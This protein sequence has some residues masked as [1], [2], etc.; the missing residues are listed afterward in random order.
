MDKEFEAYDC[1]EPLNLTTVIT[2]PRLKCDPPDP[3]VPSKA[4]TYRILQRA[5]SI[6]VKL[7]RCAATRSRT[8]FQCSAA[9]KPP[10]SWLHVAMPMGAEWKFE[11]QLLL[12]QSE[13]WT[14]WNEQ[15]YHDTYDS[16]RSYHLAVP[17][18]QTVIT[19]PSGRWTFNDSWAGC[20]SSPSPFRAEGP[21]RWG[22][23]YWADPEPRHF[24]PR[25]VITDYITIKTEKVDA[26]RDNNGRLTTVTGLHLPCLESDE[27]CVVE[28]HGTYVWKAT[29]AE[30]RCHYYSALPRPVTGLDIVDAQGRTTF[31][32][33][34]TMLRL[35][36]RGSISRCGSVMYRTDFDNLFLTED[37]W[38]TKVSR[39][40]A[41]SEVSVV[42][43]ANQQDKFLY[44]EVIDTIKEELQEMNVNQCNLGRHVK[45]GEYARQAAEQQARLDG[46]TAMVSPNHFVTAAGEVWYSYRCR[47][48][49]VRATPDNL[50]YNALPVQLAPDDEKRFFHRLGK[51]HDWDASIEEDKE[52]NNREELIDSASDEEPAE[53]LPLAR[54]FVEPRTRRLTTV[55]S[56]VQCASPTVPHYRNRQG[57]W[58][59]IDR[60]RL[61]P[62][63]APQVL[64]MI[65]QSRNDVPIG[66][67]FDW[68]DDGIYNRKV[69]ESWEKFSTTPQAAIGKMGKIVRYGS[70]RPPGLQPV[71]KEYFP[72]APSYKIYSSFSIYARFW[73]V[74]AKYGQ[75][76][77]VVLGT[78]MLIRF[79]TWV[80][81]VIFRL[82]AA[83]MTGN[84]FSHVASA[85][86]PS[87]RDFIRDNWLR[88]ASVSQHKTSPKEPANAPTDESP[89]PPP[90]P[91]QDESVRPKRGIL[92]FRRGSDVDA[93][94]HGLKKEI[95]RLRRQLRSSAPVLNTSEIQP[96]Q[97]GE[98][99][100]P[101]PSRRLFRS[102]PPLPDAPPE[103][104]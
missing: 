31:Y 62:A 12:T 29:T 69:L 58:V 37:L 23:S 90:T 47:P 32:S 71:L 36:K 86:F 70:A 104:K 7:K 101:L 11:E 66:K 41:A 10:F 68:Q 14:A 84:L 82:C 8:A 33:E 25:A 72:G 6:N 43:Y 45:E 89:S 17:G 42:T 91:A 46:E 99:E 74:V 53:K 20:S 15:R 57:S 4:K 64:S 18:K 96:L 78:G 44:H 52:M 93:G 65:H 77:S 27:K 100:T 13:C 28:G 59:A 54:F 49:I 21:R 30:E 39:P 24:F 95:H 9:A 75:I 87:A 63:V 5:K 94:D 102:A 35:E 48:I 3:H 81:G 50:C 22:A 80:T 85:F 73:D 34:T 79:I 40:L 61:Y 60:N 103:G 19:Q 55:A 38:A 2:P 56:V 51:P 76:C 83:P 26:Y 92:R 16:S 67:S 88:G 98:G 97:D 1:S